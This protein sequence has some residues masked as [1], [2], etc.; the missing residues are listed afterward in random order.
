MPEPS[1]LTTLDVACPVCREPLCATAA[2]ALG[3]SKCGRTYHL[4]QGV[5]QLTPPSVEETSE[6]TAEAFT[7]HSERFHELQAEHEHHFL[8]VIA[9]LGPE[10]FRDK[11]VLDAGSG[12]GRHAVFAARYGAREVWALDLGDSV[13]TAAKMA[14][15]EPNV[16]VAQAD[17]M[18]PPFAPGDEQRGFDFVFSIGVVHHLDD[19][20][21]ATASL[22]SLLR[23]GGELF[24]WVY[25]H[26]GNGLVLTL[27][28]PLRRL[29]TRL[30]PG[31]LRLLTLPLAGLLYGA[32]K[33][34][35]RP[36]LRTPVGR[37]LPARDTLGGLADFSFER[38]HSVVSDQ[39]VAPKTAYVRRHELQAWLEAAGLEVVE[40][41]ARNGN[42]WRGRGRRVG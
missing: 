37:R 30:R 41:T 21:A 25:A 14:E 3:C 12:P 10:F 39:L 15:D 22:A 6:R 7:W 11:R 29:S 34:A 42:S 20:A 23:P 4:R 31:S 35:Y 18:Q 2:D 38:I 13:Y 1:T 36:L 32:V 33:G 28:E 19:P 8:D 24:V 16:H 9:P 17:L 27:V 5:W 40:I 26:E